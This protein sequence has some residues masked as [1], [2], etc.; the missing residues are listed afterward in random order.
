MVDYFRPSLEPYE[1]IY[2]DIHQNPELSLTESRTARIVS[3]HLANVAFGQVI[4]NIGG[5]GV[6]GVLRNGVGP[7]VML[8][9]DMDALPV[10][11]LTGLPYA[12]Q[13]HQLDR[14]GKLQPVMHACGHDF[15]VACLMAAAEL[16]SSARGIWSGTVILLFQTGEEDGEGARL[17]VGDPLFATIPKPDVLL[18][19]H[20]EWTKSGTV[21]IRPGQALS[22]CDSFDV[23]LFGKGGHGSAPHRS[24]DPVLAACSIVVRL[25]G[26]IS[27][28]VDPAE[29]AVVTCVYIQ[30]GKAVNIVPDTVD[31]KVEVRSYKPGVR[32]AV[33]AAVKRIINAESDASGLPQRPEITQ[34]LSIP[35]I[36]NDDEVVRKL[37]LAL[38][39]HFH[40]R[41]QEM[42]RDSGSDDFSVFAE[43]L[44][45]PCAYWNFGGT[46]EATWD[47]AEREGKLLELPTGHSACF[48]PAIEPTIRTG[49]DAIALAALAFLHRRSA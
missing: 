43:A 1:A 12:S 22:A 27:R 3:R 13:K 31:M 15:H 8:R 44:G 4:P 30:A 39:G 5:Y 24:I 41:V 36:T 25:Q 35:A 42:V 49:T 29:S 14:F 47:R 20:V 32:A 9:A 28:E 19:Q 23:R 16:L 21:Q 48:A 2:R 33:V 38:R 11:E 46:D 6:V 40:G 10:E 7:T 17:M 45:V 18:G 37:T 34:T 26:I